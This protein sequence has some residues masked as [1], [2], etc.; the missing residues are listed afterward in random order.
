MLSEKKGGKNSGGPVF[1][2]ARKSYL[3]HGGVFQLGC[4]FS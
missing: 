3:F 4:K 2:G 1:G